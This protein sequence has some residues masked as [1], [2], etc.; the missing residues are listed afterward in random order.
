MRELNTDVSQQRLQEAKELVTNPESL[1]DLEFVWIWNEE[2][3]RPTR[4]N[5]KV[6][7]KLNR[8]N[9]RVFKAVCWLDTENFEIGE[10]TNFDF[11]DFIVDFVEGDI[12]FCAV[13]Q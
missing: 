8:K 9:K 5:Y 13:T 10:D 11:K 3:G 1:L 4:W 12:I 6:V 2:D 7:K